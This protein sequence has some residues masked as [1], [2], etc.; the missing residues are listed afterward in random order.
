MIL[1][2]FLL[3][4]FFLVESAEQLCID[5]IEV[6]VIFGIEAGMAAVREVFH[7]LRFCQIVEVLFL[8]IVSVFAPQNLVLV[9]IV[10]CSLI[11]ITENF[12]CLEDILEN[13]GRILVRVLIWVPLECGLLIALLNIFLCRCFI[14][15]KQF[16]V[17]CFHWG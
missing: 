2:N 8:E 7:E 12:V 4:L 3:H 14:Y 13:L 11:G 9:V 6:V 17:I 5:A 16:V 10:P 1:T 15:A